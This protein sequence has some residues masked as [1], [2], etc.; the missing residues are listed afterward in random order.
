M[1][2]FM[3]GSGSWS[4]AI[5]QVLTDN[6]LPVTIYGRNGKEV[7]DINNNHRNSKYFDNV[8]LN[9]TIKA[10]TDFNE[11]KGSDIVI[12]AVPSGASI[13]MA[14]KLNEALDKKTIVINLAKGF[15]PETFQRLSEAITDIIKPEYLQAYFALIGPSHAE[16]V[17]ERKLTTLNIV[18]EDM[19][20]AEQL[21]Q[22]F[23]ND[24]F[25]VYRNDDLIGCE[26]GSGLKNII[27]LASGMLYGLGLGDNAKASLMTRGLAEMRRF[28]T[29]KGGR[30][31]SFM[32]LCG[33]GDLIVTCTSP[34]S[35][36][37][38][39]GW[40]IGKNDDSAVF[41][42]ENTKTVEGVAACQ[43]IYKQAAKENISMPITSEVYHVL[44]ENKK[45]SEAMYDLMSRSLKS[46]M[47]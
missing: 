28:G 11:V 17:V 31:E 10:T 6:R 23:S 2:I 40:L 13:E 8:L 12:L 26:Y 29:S 15:H 41:W 3:I 43:I 1:K 35:R 47:E 46:E 44:F 45:P 4:T 7:E 36:N 16:E 30:L 33:M 38:Q 22:L 20:L 42:K 18:G 39:A 14:D 27:A 32:G 21:Q 37:W 19:E 34:H 24:Y 5:A 25:R 9:E